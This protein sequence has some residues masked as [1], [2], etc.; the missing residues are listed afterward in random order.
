MSFLFV[1]GATKTVDFIINEAKSHS[2]LAMLLI[3][4]KYVTTDLNYC[5]NWSLKLFSFK[6]HNKRW[7]G[8]VLYGYGMLSQ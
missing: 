4:T 7:L 1:I 3:V 5:I 2:L 6:N 8:L